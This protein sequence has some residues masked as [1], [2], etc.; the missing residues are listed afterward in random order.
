[1]PR[2]PM[3]R[4]PKRHLK[5][6][7]PPAAQP[8]D[9]HATLMSRLGAKVEAPSSGEKKNYRFRSDVPSAP[10]HNAVGGPASQLPKR[11]PLSEEEIEAIMNDCVVYYSTSVDT[12][13]CWFKP[14]DSGKC[15][16]ITHA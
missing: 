9:Q 11:K 15:L 8:A 4:F 13:G 5:V 2:I 3:I 12:C 10:S 7:S 1:M 16:S 14:K 6:P